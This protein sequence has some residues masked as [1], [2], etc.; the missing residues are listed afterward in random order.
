MTWLVWRQHR[1]AG[2]VMVIV[3]A[4]IAAF[5][6]PTGLQM[7]HAAKG[8]SD[9][10]AKLGHG[11]VVAPQALNDC[12]QLSQVFVNRYTPMTYVA[13]LLLFAPVLVGMF[14]GAPLVAREVEQGT[15]R[16]AWTQGVSRRRWTLTKAA[17]VGG[18]VVL[19][20]VAYALLINWWI[21]PFTVGNGSRLAS[22]LFDS[23][24]V[25]PVA[26]TLFAVA[27]GVFAGSY[28]RKVLP[29]M[30]VTLAGFAVVRLGV[31]LIARPNFGTPEIAKIPVA[32]QAIFNDFNGNLVLDRA[33]RLA[34]GTTVM[35]DAMVSCPGGRARPVPAGGDPLAAACGKPGTYNWLSYQ[36][37][38]RFW[39]FQYIEA[40]IF[41]VLAAVL[42]L[43]AF[44]KVRQIS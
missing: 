33:V 11:Q 10:V 6:V 36:P 23:Q 22:G 40:G 43:L 27:L 30:G 32:S 34:D 18:F 41:V 38:D 14:W 7:R 25:V 19:A 1:R 20:A 2:L 8:F 3:L 24:G 29:A 15:H 16:F 35:N 12:H 21:Q 17:L 42:L 4:A 37:A 13:I 44:R 26:Y 39:P 28:W 9:C 31:A 5:L